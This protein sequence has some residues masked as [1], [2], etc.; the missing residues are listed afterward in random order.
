[1]DWSVLGVGI[2]IISL[3]YTMISNI[4]Q[5]IKKDIQIIKEDIY[6]IKRDIHLIEQNIYNLEALFTERAQLEG[7]LYRVNDYPIEAKVF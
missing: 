6:E 7:R 1:M 2:A 3:I 5:D 4:T